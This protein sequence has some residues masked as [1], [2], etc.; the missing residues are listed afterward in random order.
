MKFNTILFVDKHSK[1]SQHLSGNISFIKNCILY[2]KDSYKNI[3]DNLSINYY[4]SS[5]SYKV[6]KNWSRELNLNQLNITT[7]NILNGK[8]LIIYL[9]PEYKDIAIYIYLRMRGNYLIA[10]SHGHF[11]SYYNEK[12][13]YS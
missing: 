8:Q 7:K 6:V 2:L 4:C 11:N 10:I 3:E 12:E 5:S 13:K 1:S 9:Y